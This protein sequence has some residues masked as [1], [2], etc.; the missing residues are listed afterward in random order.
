MRLRT[1]DE[2]GSFRDAL[3]RDPEIA[4]IMPAAAFD[5]LF[6][7]HRQLTHIDAIFKRLNLA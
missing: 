1:W 4:A 7:P 2:G 5:E 3:E 6:D